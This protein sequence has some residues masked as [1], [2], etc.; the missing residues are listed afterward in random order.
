MSAKGRL[1]HPSASGETITLSLCV[2]SIQFNITV[3]VQVYSSNYMQAVC[4]G[5]ESTFMQNLLNLQQQ[6]LQPFPGSA[7][8]TAN[9][10]ARAW[11]PIKSIPVGCAIDLLLVAPVTS[12]NLHRNKNNHHHAPLRDP[13][14]CTTFKPDSM[15]GFNAAR[16][17]IR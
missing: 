8:S 2:F 5:L 17:I 7:R 11:S 9:T 3:P 10:Q 16:G 15:D 4:V 14:N 1:V 6:I 13:P 12:T